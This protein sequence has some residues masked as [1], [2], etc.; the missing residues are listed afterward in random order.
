MVSTTIET[1]MNKKLFPILLVLLAIVA[2]WYWWPAVQGRAVFTA[3]S[4]SRSE[5]FASCAVG[6]GSQPTL[7]GV[8]VKTSEGSDVFIHDGKLLPSL[9][10]RIEVTSREGALTSIDPKSCSK[11]STDLDWSEANASTD[12]RNHVK[13]KVSFLCASASGM[14]IEVD[15]VLHRCELK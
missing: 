10:A 9:P 5:T 13:G 3:Q 14:R 11:F 12:I 2:V 8:H 1:S 4:S 6:F 7:F 15:A